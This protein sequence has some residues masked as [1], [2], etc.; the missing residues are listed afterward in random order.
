M[1]LKKWLRRQRGDR[2]EFEDAA[3]RV[4]EQARDLHNFVME[5]RL[6]QMN[7]TLEGRNNHG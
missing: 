3:R 5:Q 1:W 4:S 2:S 7:I 6:R